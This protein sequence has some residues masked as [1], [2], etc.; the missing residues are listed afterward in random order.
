VRFAEVSD[1][2]LRHQLATDGI[3]IDFGAARARVRSIEPSLAAMLRTVYG[4]YPIDPPQGMFDVSVTLRPTPGLRTWLRPQVQL[5]CDGVRELEPF[6][7]DTPLPLLEWGINYALASRM[8]CDLLL[9]AGV[10]ERGGAAIV[11]PAMPGSGKSTLT[12]ALSLS[13]FRLLSDEFGVVRLSDSALLPMLRPVALKN[14]SIDVIAAAFPAAVIGPRF[15]KTHKGTVA[16]LAPLAS[17]VEARHVAAQ[18]R[19][20]IF[21]RFDAAIDVDLEPVGKG[22]AFARLAVNSFNYDALGPDAFD[23]LGQVVQ[24]SSCWVLHYGNLE[25]AIAAIRRLVDE[26]HGPAPAT[27]ADAISSVEGAS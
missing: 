5:L 9:H 12:A 18:P 21:P 2:W 19:L 16:H 7:R 24:Q 13:G 25:G 10:V 8:Y 22:R 11:M 17:H 3:G 14:A 4:A 20:I 26:T 6:P 1:D 27:A 15:P 23:A